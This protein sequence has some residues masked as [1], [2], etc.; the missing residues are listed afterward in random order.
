[1]KVNITASEFQKAIEMCNHTKH[2]TISIYPTYMLLN[3]MYFQ[4]LKSLN[5]GFQFNMRVDSFTSYHFLDSFLFTF[6]I[7]DAHTHAAQLFCETKV[8]GTL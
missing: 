8:F 5:G 4:I 7:Y 1:M 3:H 6:P 2:Q